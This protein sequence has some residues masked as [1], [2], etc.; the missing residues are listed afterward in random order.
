ME[1][2]ENF[3]QSQFVVLFYGQVS[4]KLDMTVKMEIR[5]F[6]SRNHL[7]IMESITKVW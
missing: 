5:S 3:K 2:L 4:K 6:R 7:T 1:G